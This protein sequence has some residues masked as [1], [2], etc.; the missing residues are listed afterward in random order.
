MSRPK[1]ILIAWEMGGNFGH[2]AEI[3]QLLPWLEGHVE[4]FAAVRNPATLRAICPSARIKV[5]AAPFAPDALVAAGDRALSYPDVMRYVG[6]QDPD[7]LAAYLEAWDGLFDL[8]APD[9]LVAQAAPTAL[10]AARSRGLG[11]I[12]MGSG[13]C[14]PP[15]AQPMPGFHHWEADDPAEL[16]R[17]EDRV[18]ETANTALQARNQAPLR[19]FS[20]VFDVEKYLVTSLPELDHYPDRAEMDQG[21]V[22]YLGPVIGTHFGARM[23]WRAEA[24]DRI[25]AY[26]RPGNPR[27]EAAIRAFA[28][29]SKDTD[30]IL[31]APGAPEAL[32]P[33]L[34]DTPIR[35][36][37]GPV[38]MAPLLADCDL[39]VSHASSGQSAN[40]AVAGIPQ[41]GL[42]N[43]TEQTMMAHALSKSDLGLGLIGKAKP[44][45]IVRAIEIVKTSVSV[46][47]GTAGFATRWSLQ[48][49]EETSA[50]TARE[51]LSL[52]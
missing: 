44:E 16:A 5:L 4:V 29:L 25:L 30:I 46:A 11:R 23:A 28:A 42:P 24:R 9:L 52:L 20:E 34:S 50:A 18:V 37:R 14:C 43:Q 45:D 26:L 35:L 41:I 6:W 36:V 39:G 7:A 51:I 12:A 40:F 32:A 15:R 38:D 1:R 17:R 10:L 19:S 22:R 13:Y 21:E 3:A 2:A 8:V 48:Q 49:R 27:F 47:R 33:R 31:A